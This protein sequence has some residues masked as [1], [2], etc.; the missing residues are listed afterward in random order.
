MCNLPWKKFVCGNFVDD[1][2]C[3][4]ETEKP[5][6]LYGSLEICERSKNSNGSCPAGTIN[7]SIEVVSTD[8]NYS[9]CQCCVEGTKSRLNETLMTLLGAKV[10]SGTRRS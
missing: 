10:I 9:Q 6:E 8:A 7:T 2:H 4:H 5:R 3:K 1:V